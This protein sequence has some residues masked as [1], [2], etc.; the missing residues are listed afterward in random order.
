MLVCEAVKQVASRKVFVF[1]GLAYLL[2]PQQYN[3][4]SNT[5][6]F[7]FEIKWQPYS[8]PDCYEI[9]FPLFRDGRKNI[10]HTIT[11][12]EQKTDRG[13]EVGLKFFGKK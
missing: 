4:L 5:V 1:V 8:Q 11:N 10:T 6:F 7:S 9:F 13:E 3:C 12:L 2:V